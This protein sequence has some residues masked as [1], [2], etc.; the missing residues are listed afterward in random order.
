MWCRN[1]GLAKP[2]IYLGQG[3]V[4]TP[5]KKLGNVITYPYPDTK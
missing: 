2:L 3:C 4:I 5:H 1:G